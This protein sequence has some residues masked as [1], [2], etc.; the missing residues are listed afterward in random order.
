MID[1]ILYR[2]EKPANVGNIM[3]TC[4]ATKSRLII[5][6]PISFSLEEKDIKRSGMDYIEELNMT[7]YKDYEE[8]T[9][10]YSLNNI[11]YVTRYSNEIYTLFDY[12]DASISLALMFGRESTGI[13]H[14][15]LLE[16][17]DRLLRIPMVSNARSLNLSNS[18]AIVLYH[19]LYKKNFPSLSTREEIKGEDFL[20]NEK[21]TS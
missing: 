10:N 4:A 15:I 13:P 17:K 1:I 21:K 14:E 5:I 19:V 8:F 11:Y 3:R 12:G 20:F 7:F 9:K 6:G 16:H 2:P 18:V